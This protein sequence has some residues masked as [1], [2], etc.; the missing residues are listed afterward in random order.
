MILAFFCSFLLAFCNFLSFCVYIFMK[1]FCEFSLRNLSFG[2]L[3]WDL[4][5]GSRGNR[6]RK[7]L[8]E[9]TEAATTTGSLKMLYKNPLDSLVREKQAQIGL[10]GP[11]A[12][13][14][15]RFSPPH[16]STS[17]FLME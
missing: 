4:G 5:A 1:F 7:W 13:V 14:D 9:P 6:P 11:K 17:V 10:G 15:P 16:R 12:Q 2:S 8:G 3:A